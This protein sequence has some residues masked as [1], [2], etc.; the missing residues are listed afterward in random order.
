MA[1]RFTRPDQ[2][3][4]PAKI[5]EW[6]R[7][8]DWASILEFCDFKLF[9]PR[10]I[11]KARETFRQIALSIKAGPDGRAA[12][13]LRSCSNSIYWDVREASKVSSKRLSGVGS[14]RAL[15]KISNIGSH[16]AEEKL[17]TTLC[18][19][20]YHPDNDAA[21]LSALRFLKNTVATSRNPDDILASLRQMTRWL[22]I[23]GLGEMA[24][25]I[26]NLVRSEAPGTAYVDAHDRLAYVQK[27][28]LSLVFKS[29][30]EVILNYIRENAQWR[31]MDVLGNS[32][33]ASIREA[34]VKT[35]GLSL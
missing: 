6:A 9:A 32:K 2:I 3:P 24:L 14:S 1:Y 12:E 30:S 5:R 20:S 8:G 10:I 17:W 28:H 13:F 29:K 26:R 21:Y 31:L 27:T 35:L 18:F 34:K 7:K 19:E 22:E 33:D 25:W 11:P 23:V 15:E 16:A 4:H